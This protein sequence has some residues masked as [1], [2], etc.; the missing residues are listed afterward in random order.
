M[1]I[2]IIFLIVTILLIISGI[3][4]TA[5]N[6]DFIKQISSNDELL[7]LP[8]TVKTT[9]SQLM[10]EPGL[11][12]ESNFI[13]CTMKKG[14]SL[15]I[16]DF[17]D[18]HYLVKYDTMFGYVSRIFVNETVKTIQLR[19]KKFA[20]ENNKR[21]D[22]RKNELA[23]KYGEK[24]AQRIINMQIWI[25]MTSEMAID[26]WGHPDDINKTVLENNIREQWIYRKLNSND[27]YLY[28][29]NEV[30]TSWQD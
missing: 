10:K 12:S 26:S 22:I 9:G 1:K 28:F 7:G 8:T 29:D 4:L 6:T 23:I 14:D 18:D 25:G 13:L 11:A 3:T 2:S 21:L 15:L 17:K 24:D 5:Q 19:D 27:V 30:L 20:E 16:F